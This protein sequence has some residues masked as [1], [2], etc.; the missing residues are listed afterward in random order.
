MKLTSRELLITLDGG[1][2][3]RD[4]CRRYR[5]E[6]LLPAV[7]PPGTDKII[8]PLLDGVM[9][10]VTAPSSLAIGAVEILAIRGEL[11]PV[12][13]NGR[14]MTFLTTPSVYDNDALVYLNITVGGQ[15]ASLPS[16]ADEAAGRRQWV[17]QTIA[18][19]GL[20]STRT[21]LRALTGV[22]RR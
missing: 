17:V 10:S 16:P 2:T 18:E 22:A 3:A 14:R 21:V 9:N 13:K 1:E 8:V 19:G 15:I 12:V 11:G 20:P 6:L 7:V 5:R 4:R